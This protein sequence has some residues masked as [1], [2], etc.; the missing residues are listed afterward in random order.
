M[1][2]SAIILVLR[3]RRRRRLEGWGPHGR[4]ALHSQMLRRIILY[5]HNP[6]RSRQADR[7]A[8]SGGI[9]RLYSDKKTGSSR[10]LGILR[11]HHRCHRSR[12]ADQG[13]V[14]CK[15]ESIDRRRLC[16]PSAR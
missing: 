12:T 4:L 9:W 11:A 13:L 6:R 16:H 8:P 3:S 1:L 15:K 2:A 5:R 14:T 7:R 10:I